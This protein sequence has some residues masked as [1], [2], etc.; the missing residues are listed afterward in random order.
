[1]KTGTFRLRAIRIMQH[2][3]AAVLAFII[4]YSV[5]GTSIMIQGL[6][7]YYSYNLYESD[8]ARNYDESYLFNNILGNSVSDILRHVAVRTQLETKGQYDDRK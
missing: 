8:R 6:S 2:L 1:M 5:A 7:G 3:L 4:A